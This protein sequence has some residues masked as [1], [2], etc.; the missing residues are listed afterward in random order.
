MR[1]SNVTA[2]PQQ[3]LQPA[4]LNRFQPLQQP[5][6]TVHFSAKTKA[7]SGNKSDEQ[8]GFSL[9]T[10][11]NA[12][13]WATL[14]P[15]KATGQWMEVRKIRSLITQPT[16]TVQA[17][18][19]K[20]VAQNKIKGAELITWLNAKDSV[21]AE[22]IRP[23]VHDT[24]NE[25]SFG[26][27]QSAVKA[28]TTLTSDELKEE[29]LWLLVHDGDVRVQSSV[30]SAV[31]TFVKDERKEKFLKV[32]TADPDNEVRQNAA[33]VIGTIGKDAL[34]EKLVTPLLSDTDEDVRKALPPVVASFQSNPLK[35][36]LLDTLLSNETAVSVRSQLPKVA[37]S[38]T[39]ETLIFKYLKTLASD[40]YPVTRVQVTEVLNRQPESAA[41][42]ECL[43]LLSADKNDDVLRNVAI[44][45]SV[46]TEDG[47]K[48]EILKP[49][50][51]SKN[52]ATQAEAIK[53]LASVKDA[54]LRN[55]QL[56]DVVK[57]PVWLDQF[58][59]AWVAKHSA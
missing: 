52:A 9:M 30:P 27:R 13:G 39:D 49:I 37:E 29:L 34:K 57:N 7:S 2:Y 31:A 35:A 4:R 33:P 17:G 8:D 45:A 21:K 48:L 23:L 6:T 15:F 38:F 18:Q 32:L 53:S 42:I 54:A 46:L 24:H 40:Q 56:A 1:V 14:A 36:A 43:K 58:F 22:L 47:D 3:P 44:M 28:I 55:A 26:V 20:E 25:F 51:Q 10:I 5:T 19:L 11:P 50:L 41:K 12:I 16:Q 59:S